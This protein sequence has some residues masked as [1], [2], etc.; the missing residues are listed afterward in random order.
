M[1]SSGRHVACAPNTAEPHGGGM[2]IN[3]PRARSVA[4]QGAYAQNLEAPAA[5]LIYMPHSHKS[6]E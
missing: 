1:I 4:S 2:K 6:L 3:G 5:T